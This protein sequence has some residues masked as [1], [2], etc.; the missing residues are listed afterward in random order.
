MTYAALHTLRYSV[1]PLKKGKAGKP[2]ATILWVM[3]LQNRA[4]KILFFTICSVATYQDFPS[5]VCD[6]IIPHWTSD[7]LATYSTVWL[8]GP[9]P[10]SPC[11]SPNT[12]NIHFF[13]LYAQSSLPPWRF[14]LHCMPGCQRTGRNR[15]EILRT[16]GKENHMMF[17]LHLD[18]M[19]GKKVQMNTKEGERGETGLKICTCKS[20]YN[21]TYA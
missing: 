13:Q 4:F 8:I 2:T 1:S 12:R 5:H 7:E 6:G 15:G 21:S 9:L 3:Q 18:G 11:V 19:K 16:Y 14:H 17:G 20:T 10:C